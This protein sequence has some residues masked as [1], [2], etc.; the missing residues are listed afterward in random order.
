MD[1]EF[2]SSPELLEYFKKESFKPFKAGGLHWSIYLIK[3]YQGTSLLYFRFHHYL[4]D[5]VGAAVLACGL[6][7]AFH[8]K[9]LPF[10]RDMT[11][12]EILIKKACMLLMPYH[13]VLETLKLN[14]ANFDRV[15]IFN[16]KESTT[17]YNMCESKD[18]RVEDLKGVAK[19]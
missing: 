1:E 4:I 12:R 14:S 13:V 10:I 11:P 18:Y 16:S 9:Q 8:P 6:Q 2:K 7:D 15:A 19:R 17:S 5:G 3:N